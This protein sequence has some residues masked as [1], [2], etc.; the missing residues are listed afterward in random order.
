MFYTH[1]FFLNDPFLRSRIPIPGPSGRRKKLGKSAHLL[2]KEGRPRGA[3]CY[4]ME[5]KL[6]L[7]FPVNISHSSVLCH[8]GK[9]ADVSKSLSS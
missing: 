4:L 2:L 7:S 9:K 8:S 1:S 5:A 6:H 3:H